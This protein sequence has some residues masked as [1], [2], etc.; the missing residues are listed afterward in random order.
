MG[1]FLAFIGLVVDLIMIILN[2]S[3]N[4]GLI[5]T[6]GDMNDQIIW[7]TIVNGLIIASLKYY[8]T[9]GSLLIGILLTSII[10]FI[11]TEKEICINTPNISNPVEI[12]SSYD[13]I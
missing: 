11:K 9:K 4:S 2:V 8:K 7:L 6:L 5:L 1:T 3:S 13:T 12:I 10:Y